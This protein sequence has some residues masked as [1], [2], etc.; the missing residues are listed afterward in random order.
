MTQPQSN[1]RFVPVRAYERFR[2]GKLE[3]VCNHVRSLPRRAA[4]DDR[5]DKEV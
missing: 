1:A 4:N 2:K 3:L 5:F